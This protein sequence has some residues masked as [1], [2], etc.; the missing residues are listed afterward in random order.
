MKK[1]LWAI[2]IGCFLSTLIIWVWAMSPI[3]VWDDRDE[4]G[5]IWSAWYI[6]DEAS[7][8]CVRPWEK[9]EMRIC[10][11]EYAPV[12]GVDWVTYGNACGAGDTKIAYRGECDSMIDSKRMARLERL[13]ERFSKKVE[14]ISFEKRI[15]AIEVINERI[16]IVKMSRIATWVQKERITNLVFLRNIFEH[17]P[18]SE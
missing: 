17:T 11:M 6:W 8:E 4:H 18:Y 1:I 15:K 12:C 2:L 5:C 14:N 16:E 3:M 7:G 9:E 13:S 10:T